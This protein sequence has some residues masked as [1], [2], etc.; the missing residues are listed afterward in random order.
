MPFFQ[1]KYLQNRNFKKMMVKW[2]IGVNAVQ[3]SG[4]VIKKIKK[5]TISGKSIKNCHQRPNLK[6]SQL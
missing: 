6:D 5:K 2:N 3:V 4:N 1:E